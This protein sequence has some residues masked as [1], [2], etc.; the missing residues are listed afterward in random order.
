MDALGGQ[1][2]E[3]IERKHAE[4]AMLESEARKRA[5]LDAALDA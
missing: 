1:I 5:I 3:Y 4:E 2:G